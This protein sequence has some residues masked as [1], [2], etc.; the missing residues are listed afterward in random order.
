[1]IIKGASRSNGVQLGQYLLGLIGH[2]EDEITVLDVEH[3]AGNVMAATCDMQAATGSGQRGTK[4]LY[5]AQISPAIGE[6][7]EMSDADWRRCAD[8]L[9]AQLGFE[10]QSRVLVLH[11]KEGRKHLHV[12]WQR[13]DFKE[14]N[15][16]SDGWN[17]IKHELAARQLEK[18]LGHKHVK[19]VHLDGKE[20]RSDKAFDMVLAEQA[21]RSKR[22]PM[23]LK[24]DISH[25]W[26]K[27]D[28]AQAFNTALADQGL[29]LAKGDK[30][31]HVVIDEQGEIY[32]LSRQLRG[33][34]KTKEVKDRLSEIDTRLYPSVTEAQQIQ[35]NISQSGRLSKEADKLARQQ[36]GQRLKLETSQRTEARQFMADQ[37][38]ERKSYDNRARDFLASQRDQDKP[39]HEV[40]IF[41]LKALGQY[42]KHL[43]KRADRDELRVEEINAARMDFRKTQLKTKGDFKHILRR[44]TRNLRAN[45]KAKVQKLPEREQ[46]LIEDR[47]KQYIDQFK[48]VE[49]EDDKEDEFTGKVI[50][51]KSQKETK[52]TDKN[53]IILPPSQRSEEERRKW[54]KEK[55]RRTLEAQ[56]RQGKEEDK[57]R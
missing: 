1:M 38:A 8:V 44:D 55:R 42:D 25:A 11:E 34:A 28:T 31:A 3:L 49:K 56:Q 46:A 29:I 32:S 17:Y 39:P 20:H 41:F 57:D 47:I 7:K 30:R 35:R 54:E 12:A 2:E 22:D 52:E 26:Q 50:L 16:K 45:Q 5:H 18:E 27:S 6:D 24:K 4:G 21:S 48:G 23:E 15:L 37:K 10:G 53:K 36:A 33:T 13:Y 14:G 19:G 43:K 9:E 40:F 51:P